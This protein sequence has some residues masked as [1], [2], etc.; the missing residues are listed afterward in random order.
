MSKARD[1]LRKNRDLVFRLFDYRCVK[2]G[3]PANQ[4]H[5]IEPISHGKRTLR[6]T[7]QVPLCAGC[8]TWAHD[9]GTSI[10]MTILAV[11][12]RIFLTRKWRIKC[13]RLSGKVQ[14]LE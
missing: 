1:Q 14:K 12:R 5:E 9:V 3:S 4:I 8:H 11:A 7:N 6:V 2:C 10:S 13:Q